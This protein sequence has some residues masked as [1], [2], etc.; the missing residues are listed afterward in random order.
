MARGNVYLL[1]H[2]DSLTD[3]PP[4]KT[5]QKYTWH[6]IEYDQD[7]GIISDVEIIPTWDQLADHYFREYGDRV[8]G[9]YQG[10]GEVYHIIEFDASFEKGEIQQI[11]ALSKNPAHPD[12]PNGTILTATE[13]DTFSENGTI[14]I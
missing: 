8:S 13:A 5:R 6:K 1:V 11:M 9:T 4:L 10:N 2:G 7:G 12:Y 3:L 14:A